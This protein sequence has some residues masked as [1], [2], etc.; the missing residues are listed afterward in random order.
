MKK[1][2]AIPLKGRDH[3]SI[4]ADLASFKEDD[5]RWQE[6]RTWSMVYHVDDAH[7]A[8]LKEAGN[9]FFSESYLNP[10][11]F[12]SL[13]RMELDVIAMAKDLLHGDEEVT[14]TMTSGGTESIFLSVYTYRE[15]ARQERKLKKTPELVMAVSA[16]P[17][18]EKAA[19]MLGIKVKKAPLD[20]QY[21]VDVKA[22]EK[23]IS[24]NTILIVASAPSYPH[25]I[26]DPIE[27]I[28]A[29]A[30]QH[31][32]PFHVDSCIG[33]F[34]LP[35]VDK[36]KPGLIAPWDF[37]LPGVTSISADTHK[38]AYGSKGSSVLLYRNINYL[39]HQFFIT[40]DWPGGIYASPTFMGSRSGIP[41]ATAWASMQALGQEGYLAI[42]EKI[43]AG[44]Q[45][46]KDG[47]EAIPELQIIGQPLTNIFAFTSAHKKVDLFVVAD[48]LAGKGWS[49]D[50][51][52]KPDSIH[53]T[54]MQ[55][56]LEVIDQYLSDL[57]EAVSY[58]KSTP[59][60]KTQG[61]AALYGLM[62][63]LPLRGMVANNVRKLFEDLYSPASSSA[64]EA[65]DN[66][67]AS[68][69]EAAPWMGWLNKILSYWQRKQ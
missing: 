42:M 3:Q 56:N 7:K 69:P 15:K 36:L 46:F 23:L 28:S 52:H 18:F 31:R 26:I 47:V 55:H 40:T 12:K 43:L 19:H 60:A 2:N 20:K 6:G 64:S 67:A 62:A 68:G 33:G 14:G 51:Q 11:A 1:N 50:R 65:A 17:A 34:V 66:E 8:F 10:F 63:R 58:A 45:R 49:V 39:R 21:Q 41:I 37:R 48:V 53:F 38:F 16:H 54:V 29:L 32:V 13:Q 35:W 30:V 57:K 61:D 27:A 9:A 24:P 22:L 4:L 59:N 44:V 25:G 5:A